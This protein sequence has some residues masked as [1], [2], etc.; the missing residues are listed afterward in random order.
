MVKVNILELL[1]SGKKFKVPFFERD[2]IYQEGKMN[3]LLEGIRISNYHYFDD[4]L[5]YEDNNNLI[6]VDGQQRLVTYYLLCCAVASKYYQLGNMEGYEDVKN[7]YLI[8]KDLFT[9]RGDD[10]SVLSDLSENIINNGYHYFFKNPDS[11]VIKAFKYIYNRL[12]LQ[13]HSFKGSHYNIDVIYK[14]MG[15]LKCEYKVINKEDAFS[16]FSKSNKSSLISKYNS[17]V[18]MKNYFLE[19]I[20]NY[21]DFTNKWSKLEKLPKLYAKI[22]S[23]DY[24]IKRFFDRFI[25][26]Y[27]TIQLDYVPDYKELFSEFKNYHKFSNLT[28]D[29]YYNEIYT[30]GI[31]Y[32]NLFL[33]EEFDEDLKSVFN[34][35]TSACF[36]NRLDDNVYKG[37][38]YYSYEEMQVFLLKVY[39]DYKEGI[40]NK[41]DL[42][43]I[44]E[45]IESYIIRRDLCDITSNNL[46]DSFIK[47]YNDINKKDYLNSFKKN[48]ILLNMNEEFPDDNKLKGVMETH[49]FYH[50]SE[51]NNYVLSS[52]E[53]YINGFEK[54]FSTYEI[55]HILPKTITE[56]WKYDL[57][58]N[59]EE[60]H[61]QY[62]NTLG[63]LTLLEKSYNRAISNKSFYEKT[64]SEG[65]GYTSS[66]VTLTKDIHNWENWNE[67]SIKERTM[68]LT[69][70]IIKI[71]PYPKNQII[72]DKQQETDIYGHNTLF[73]LVNKRIFSLN[74]M[75]IEE[76]S[77]DNITYSLYNNIIVKII[78][79]KAFL[80]MIINISSENVIEP[81][82]MGKYYPTND[83][84]IKTYIH[85]ESD[86]DYIIPLI[87]QVTQEK[88]TRNLEEITEQIK[89]TYTLEHYNLGK[90]QELFLNLSEQITNIDKNIKQFNN[91]YYIAYKINNRNIINIYPNEDYLDI[92]I[93]LP[94]ENINLNELNMVYNDFD[95]KTIELYLE[96]SE[97]L[98]QV[99][100]LIEQSYHFITTGEL[101]PTHQK[102]KF[103]LEHYGLTEGTLTRQLFDEI[104]KQILSIKEITQNNTTNYISFKIKKTNFIIIKNRVDYLELEIKTNSKQ[105]PKKYK[106]NPEYEINKKNVTIYIDELEDIPHAMELINLLYKQF[107]K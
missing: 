65:I 97:Q 52:I 106:N 83:N 45:Y 13:K 4:L 107:L 99:L 49:D 77:N 33:N 27:L 20:S 24:K 42:I 21:N 89:E 6:I 44:T 63:N 53:N 12:D 59:W 67:E 92:K 32:M 71:W 82:N 105:I 8:Q 15:K 62:K 93:K 25:K 91:K 58:L 37:K 75:I 68:I 1:S 103:N 56:D 14:N 35:I 2:Y 43:S 84:K 64:K 50:E 86:I 73:E 18:L 17:N 61:D 10:K 69:E 3:K 29:E 9:L 39:R 7:N 79:Q 87:K 55:E 11:E 60:I 23:N 28:Y 98:T 94:P 30:Y 54:D 101:P 19:N 90:F 72:K 100:S 22:N 66:K 102:Q 34:H 95:E 96:K 36:S 57:G 48:I 26:D 76:K 78:D 80:E 31:Y 85:D 74:N 46:S 81:D 41:E 70:K 104:T 88:N 47:L 5:F 38:Q 16:K 51:I 40:I